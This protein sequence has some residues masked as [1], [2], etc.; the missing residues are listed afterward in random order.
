LH[1]R[2]DATCRFGGQVCSIGFEGG[3]AGW[4]AVPQSP[5]TFDVTLGGLPAPCDTT[6]VVRVQLTPPLLVETTLMLLVPA[7]RLP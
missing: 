5:L 7:G 4:D 2:R 3:G 1:R 6:S